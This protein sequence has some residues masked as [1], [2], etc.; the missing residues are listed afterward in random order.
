MGL[1]TVISMTCSD[2]IFAIFTT[3]E[4]TIRLGAQA[5][6]IISLGFIIS[7]ISVACSGVFEGLGEG[8]PSLYISLS[9]YIVIML[10]CAFILSRL[11]GAVGVWYAF[12]LTELLTA[13]LTMWLY[14]RHLH[15]R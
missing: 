9:R 10:P 5:L 4:T 11:V 6:R 13:L 15:H 2:A 14:K 1:G 3:E 12:G 7:G 8:L